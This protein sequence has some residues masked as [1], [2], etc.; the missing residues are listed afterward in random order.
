MFGQYLFLYPANRVSELL[1][2]LL[3]YAT[4]CQIL[5]LEQNYAFSLFQLIFS[6][7]IL[8]DFDDLLNILKVSATSFVCSD[9]ISSLKL[10]L[11]VASGMPL[12]SRIRPLIGGKSSKLNWLFSAKVRYFSASSTCKNTTALQ[13]QQKGKILNLLK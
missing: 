7:R 13:A 12:R 1:S 5:A 6:Q 9:T 11:L 4:S 2:S 3:L 8:T 10:S